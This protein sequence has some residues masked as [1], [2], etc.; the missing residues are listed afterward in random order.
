M[1]NI[2]VLWYPGECP[3]GPAC[4]SGSVDTTGTVVVPEPEAFALVVA[5]LGLLG[6]VARQ[7]KL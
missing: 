2:L 6:F 7:R 3:G 4:V 5:G 1:A